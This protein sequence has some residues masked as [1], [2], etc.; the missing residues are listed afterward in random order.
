[1]SRVTR[2]VTFK[3][4]IADPEKWNLKHIEDA[5]AD[6]ESDTYDDWATNSLIEAMDVAASKFIAEHPDL[7]VEDSLTWYE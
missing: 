6:S 5:E 1:M 3:T 2:D 7:F 4:I